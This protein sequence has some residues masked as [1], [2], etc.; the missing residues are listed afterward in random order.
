MSVRMGSLPLLTLPSEQ[1]PCARD[2][3]A[4]EAASLPERGKAWGEKPKLAG[5]PASTPRHDGDK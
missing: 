5:K 2:G 4:F 3:L 1:V